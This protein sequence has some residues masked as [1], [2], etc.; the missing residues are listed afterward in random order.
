M[1]DVRCI[2]FMTGNLNKTMKV[3]DQTCIKHKSNTEKLKGKFY[4]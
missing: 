1:N 2:N 4:D 3:N